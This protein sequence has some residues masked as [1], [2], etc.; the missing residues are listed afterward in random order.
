MEPTLVLECFGYP[1]WFKGAA[2]LRCCCSCGRLLR[3][4]PA[5]R[6]QAAS[7]RWQPADRK[8]LGWGGKVKSVS[9]EARA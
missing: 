1:V 3:S 6:G 8:E 7:K 4:A 2:E 5:H 9:L